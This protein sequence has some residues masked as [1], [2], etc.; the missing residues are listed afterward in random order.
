MQSQP[1]NI[2]V[3]FDRS[4]IDPSIKTASFFKFGGARTSRMT[5]VSPLSSNMGTSV[6]PRSPDPPVRSTFIVFSPAY[7]FFV[8]EYLAGAPE[9]WIPLRPP[10][11]RREARPL[12][13][14]SRQS[15][16]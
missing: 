1:G 11:Q 7:P 10:D 16:S 5:G 3:N 15:F 2:S 13:P 6:W 9:E 12:T 8:E 4:R 14:H